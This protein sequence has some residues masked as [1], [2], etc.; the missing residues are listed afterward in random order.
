M[1]GKGVSSRVKSV[2]QPSARVFRDAVLNAKRTNPKG[3]MVDAHSVSDYQRN[4]RLFM[5]REGTAGVAVHKKTGNI[6]SVFSS[7]SGGNAMGYLIPTAIEAGGRRLDAFADGLHTM[8]G[9]HGGQLTGRVKFDPSQAPEGWTPGMSEPDVVMMTM[10]TSLEEWG[11]QYDGK[12]QTDLF[13]AKL[14]GDWDGM[15]AAT[16][17]ALDERASR[18]GARAATQAALG[19]GR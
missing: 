14:Y 7:Q 15:D 4:Y 2:Y 5:D 18:E 8:Y 6:V 17:K 1:A 10:P 3:W 16:E 12:R 19:G 9:R 11:R 13:S